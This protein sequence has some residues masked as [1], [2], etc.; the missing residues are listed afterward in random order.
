MAEVWLDTERRG[1]LLSAIEAGKTNGIKIRLVLRPW[2]NVNGQDESDRTI[3]G[4]TGADLHE[5]MPP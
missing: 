4:E 5:W 3:L 2:L 1:A